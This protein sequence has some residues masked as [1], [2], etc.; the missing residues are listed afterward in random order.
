[1]RALKKGGTFRKR[2][3]PTQRLSLHFPFSTVSFSSFDDFFKQQ[4]R[5]GFWEQVGNFRKSGM[6]V[7]IC[8]F[9]TCHRAN[10]V[11]MRKREQISG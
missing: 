6:N 9:K 7:E 8:G 3:P 10:Y 1:M 5:Q 4:G 11:F 2:S